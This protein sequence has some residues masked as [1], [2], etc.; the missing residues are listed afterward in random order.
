MRDALLVDELLKARFSLFLTYDFVKL[1]GSVYN[2]C[3]RMSGM[4]L[5]ADTV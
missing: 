5:N 1:Q 2:I 4:L 3:F